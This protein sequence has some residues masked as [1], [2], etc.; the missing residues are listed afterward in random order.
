MGPLVLVHGAF[1]GGW[2]WAR[3]RSGLQASG[4]ALYTPTLTGLG[5]RA[6]LASPAVDFQ[7]H[8]KDVL[9]LL[10]AEELEGVTLV[11]HSSSGALVA[12]VADLA[13]QRIGHLVFFDGSVPDKDRVLVTPPPGVRERLIDGYLCPP[14]PLAMQG[15]PDSHPEAEWYRRRRTPMPIGAAAADF[16][17]SGA[18][19][20]RRMSFIHCTVDPNP[21][22]ARGVAA[23]SALGAVVIELAATH[24]AMATA[25]ALTE[26]LLVRL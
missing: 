8:A 12:M 22:A 24:A 18:W 7:M 9:G 15:V 26:S 25:P 2:C 4:R 6:H 3:V 17:L 19:T 13:P 5:E 20:T 21:H 14:P 23:A 16:P 10:E 11:G 1:T